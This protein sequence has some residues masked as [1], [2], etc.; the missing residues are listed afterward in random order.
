MLAYKIYFQLMLFVIQLID[1]IAT[2]LSRG[3]M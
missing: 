1:P 3:E 2:G